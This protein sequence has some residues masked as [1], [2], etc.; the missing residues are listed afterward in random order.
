MYNYD[1]RNLERDFP[2]LGNFNYSD[3]CYILNDAFNEW[4]KQIPDSVV[5]DIQKLQKDSE[6]W[7]SNS[8]YICVIGSKIVN[9]NVS[10]ENVSCDEDERDYKVSSIYFSRDELE[11][12]KSRKK[13]EIECK[14]LF[15]T[16]SSFI[17]KQKLEEII[18]DEYILKKVNKAFL[19][20][21]PEP[22]VY[23]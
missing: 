9:L 6:F 13:D 8:N 12:K 21:I 2:H 19:K 5:T 17:K 23:I 16:F 14:K 15:E 1:T 7:N 10:E 3:L 18:T 22:N 20:P 11:N 4:L